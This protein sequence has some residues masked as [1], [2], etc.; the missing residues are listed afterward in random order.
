MVLTG[1]NASHGNP[2]LD[3]SISGEYEVMKLE[4]VPRGFVEQHLM[5]FRDKKNY[6]DYVA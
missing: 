6:D 1:A 4:T 5:P 2:A 3:P